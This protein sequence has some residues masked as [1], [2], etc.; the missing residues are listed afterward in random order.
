MYP[1]LAKDILSPKPNKKPIILLIGVLLLITASLEFPLAGMFIFYG[2]AEDLD[3]GDTMDIEGKIVSENGTNLSGVRVT[4]LNT[5]LTTISDSQGNYEIRNAP[6]GIWRIRTSLPGYKQETHKLLLQESFG[7]DTDEDL[8]LEYN[9]QIQEGSGE[10]EHNELWL[11]FTLA[12]IMLLFS[13]FILAGAFLAF[14]Q[15][16][17]AVV[18]VGGILGMFTMTP[19][20]LF[21]FIPS[22]FAMGIIG[23]LLSSF[24]MFT[25]I[26]NRKEFA[27]T[28]K[29]REIEEKKKQL[30]NQGNQP[31]VPQKSTGS[32][33]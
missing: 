4:I 2:T 28:E 1:H 12:I 23:F 5:G 3:F 21:A 8:I 26:T 10:V 20:L 16:R 25:T 31:E 9:F 32:K 29:A 30:Q 22:I 18:L 33:E 15:R 19:P 11:F 7:T 6:Q 24:A 27:E 17:F 13:I 14:K